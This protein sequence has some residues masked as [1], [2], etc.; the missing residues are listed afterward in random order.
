MPYLKPQIS[1]ITPFYDTDSYFR[2]CL[3]SLVKQTYDNIEIIL[4]DDGSSDK[5]LE[6]ALEY[7]RK[8]PRIFIISKPNGGQSS[9]RNLGLEFIKGT[10]LRE[11]LKSKDNV[12]LTPKEREFLDLVK[13]KASNHI[14]VDKSVLET[15]ISKLPE[16][17]FVHFVD[18]D[19]FITLECIKDCVDV[20]D[21]EVDIVWHGMGSQVEGYGLGEFIVDYYM[22]SLRR[23]SK[24][25]VST[26]QILNDMYFGDLPWVCH[27]IFRADKLNVLDLRFKYIE[28]E[29]H[30]FG[31]LLFLSCSV[32]ISEEDFKAHKNLK[33]INK[34]SYIYRIRANSTC[35]YF[36]SKDI[37]QVPKHL[38]PISTYFKDFSKLRKYYHAYCFSIVLNELLN[39]KDRFE[40]KTFKRIVQVYLPVSL[41]LKRPSIDPLNAKALDAKVLEYI[42]TQ[43]FSYRFISTKPKT[44]K[45]FYALRDGIY[46]SFKIA[47]RAIVLTLIA[48]GV[49]ETIKRLLKKEANKDLP[50]EH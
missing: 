40:P 21:K 34:Q 3:D 23:S 49:K 11:A 27:G 42:S 37:G 43:G 24:K 9:A 29:D 12:N 28:C 1:I 4:I 10:N 22:Q 7:A 35:D 33:I 41:G 6:I 5:S 16:D 18:S 32:G 44:A 38:K 26:Y 46:F 19:D 20:L 45:T 13:T 48:L 47:R 17:S 14:Y 30:L 25:I 15:A 8:D 36:K 50:L 31:L 39:N 2:D